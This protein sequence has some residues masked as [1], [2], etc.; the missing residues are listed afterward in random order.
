VQNEHKLGFSS[1]EFKN[2]P[3]NYHDLTLLMIEKL[4]SVE[5][6]IAKKQ[7]S[8]LNRFFNT[9][10]IDAMATFDIEPTH[11]I[12]YLQ[13]FVE[14]LSD[15]LHNG[16]VDQNSQMEGWLQNI[17]KNFEEILGYT[18]IQL[19]H[20]KAMEHIESKLQIIQ[21]S[22]VRYKVSDEFL[23]KALSHQVSDNY[24]ETLI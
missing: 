16:H 15:R 3:K 4:Q 8:G 7:S 21:H 11:K 10:V 2:K 9:D 23:S 24:K 18:Q 14:H 22:I 20:Q 12:D 13:A 6:Q 5:S 19:K 17:N 1:Y